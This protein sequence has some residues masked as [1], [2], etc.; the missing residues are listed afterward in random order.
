MTSYKSVFASKTF[1]GAI[2][3]AA[4]VIVPKLA[5]FSLDSIWPTA[6]VIVGAVVAIIGRFTAKKKV[7]LTGS[8]PSA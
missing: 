1:W 7:T 5:G 3:S 4:G 6:T 2:L 8:S